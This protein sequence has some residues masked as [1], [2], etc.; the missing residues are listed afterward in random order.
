M[1]RSAA[2]VLGTCLIGALYTI[3]P[4][5]KIGQEF[6]AIGAIMSLYL[7]WLAIDLCLGRRFA[8]YARRWWM[9]LPGGA[10]IAWEG[11]RLMDIAPSIGMCVAII[12]LIGF[13]YFLL[14]P[15]SGAFKPD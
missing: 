8:P 4:S 12:M 9:V 5:A 1:G 7:V 2:F 3:M 6:V 11:A 15:T 14:Q 10:V 13:L